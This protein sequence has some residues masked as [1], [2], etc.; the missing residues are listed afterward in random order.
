MAKVRIQLPDSIRTAAPKM[1]VA[2]Q[3]KSAALDAAIA[4]IKDNIAALSV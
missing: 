2:L 4:M 1:E 3:E